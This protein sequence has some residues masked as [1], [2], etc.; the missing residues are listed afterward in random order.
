MSEWGGRNIILTGF[1]GT[2]KSTVG[3]RVAAR[4][5]G[6]FVDTDALIEQEE[7]MPIS[8]IF[9]EKGEAYFRQREAHVIDRVCRG[10]GRVITTG[11][12]AVADAANAA[13]LKGSGTVVCLTARPEVILER[14]RGNTDRP[15]LRGEDP[16]GKIRA[17]LAAR[18][19]AYAKADV[20]IDTSALAVD[21][22]VEA[23]LRAV[24]V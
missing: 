14:V 7:G 23:V 9:A 11:G 13:R 5:G 16:L 4:V 18:A 22:V 17:L 12:G 6:E 1:M 8:R 21:D 19:E 10:G 3:K 15:L 2:G 20:M 24:G